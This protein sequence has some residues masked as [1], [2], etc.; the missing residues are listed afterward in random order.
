MPM[1]FDDVNI[2]RHLIIVI[3]HVITEIL[4]SIFTENNQHIQ[5]HIMRTNSVNKQWF[6]RGHNTTTDGY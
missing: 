1:S 6:N 5:I 3:R 2:L 4:A